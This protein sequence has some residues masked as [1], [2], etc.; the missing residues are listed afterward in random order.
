MTVNVH[1]IQM[2]DGEGLEVTVATLTAPTRVTAVRD[3]AGLLTFTNRPA[4]N[5]RKTLLGASQLDLQLGKSNKTYRL[6][7]DY[8]WEQDKITGRNFSINFK[9]MFLKSASTAD[10]ED[11]FKLLFEAGESK[12]AELYVEFRKYLGVVTVSSVDY[13]RYQVEA[14]NIKV[15]NYAEN[16]PADGLIDVSATL[17]GQGA[18]IYGFENIEIV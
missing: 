14:G 2:L 15:L 16:A 12:E 17:K 8:G 18:Y 1:P 7:N 6:F 10:L 4:A 5:L 11:S 3:N 13:N 9:G